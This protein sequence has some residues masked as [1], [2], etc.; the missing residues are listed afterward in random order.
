MLEKDSAGWGGG[1]GWWQ[2]SW[3]CVCRQSLFFFIWRNIVLQCCVGFCPTTTQISHNYT[4]IT[5]FLSLPLLP[6]NPSRSS[7]APGWA[8]YTGSLLKSS[9]GKNFEPFDFRSV[10]ITCCAVI[11]KYYEMQEEVVE[12]H[13]PI[14]QMVSLRE[15]LAQHS[16]MWLLWPCT[17]ALRW[18]AAPIQVLL[19]LPLLLNQ[20]LPQV[21]S[22]RN[23]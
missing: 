15:E 14:A 13:Y 18:H 21:L 11:V 3:G 16:W 8:P 20:S 19:E 9:F 4:S 6:P 5:Y 17:L 22:L 2:S 12:L 7:Q 1:V 23:C 10:V